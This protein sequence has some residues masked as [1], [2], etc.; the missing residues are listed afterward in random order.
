MGDMLYNCRS[1]IS[2]NLSNFNS[3]KITNISHMLYNCNSLLSI[4]L[5]NANIQNMR[6]KRYIFYNCNSLIH[7]ISEKFENY[8]YFY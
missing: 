7:K 1:L 3:E 4:N 5:A 2:L 6:N 8:Y